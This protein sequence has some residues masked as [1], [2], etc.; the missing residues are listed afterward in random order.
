M[1]IAKKKED[2]QDLEQYYRQVCRQEEIVAR[3][4]QADIQCK[5][6]QKQY[7]DNLVQNF[8]IIDSEAD[9]EA[10]KIKQVNTQEIERELFGKNANIDA[11]IDRFERIKEKRSP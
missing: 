7:K 4:I 10:N 5:L 8:K 2:K 3:E 9:E 6:A 1:E 11:L